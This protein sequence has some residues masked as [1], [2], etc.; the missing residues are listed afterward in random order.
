MALTGFAAVLYYGIIASITGGYL[1]FRA[2]NWWLVVFHLYL[3]LS[4]I[5]LPLIIFLV[6][7]PQPQLP[8]PP[9]SPLPL[10]PP[11]LFP[12]LPNQHVLIM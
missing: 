9:P 6:S 3:F 2:K 5:V 8:S 11:P 1:P 4:F 7:A 12:C 10:S